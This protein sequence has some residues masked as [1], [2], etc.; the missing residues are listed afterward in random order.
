MVMWERVV[1]SPEGFRGPSPHH[2]MDPINALQAAIEGY[3]VTTMNEASKEGNIFD[4]TTGGADTIL[5]QHFEQMK[6]DAIVCNIG[7]FDVEIEVKW[8][9]ENAVETVNIKPQ[10]VCYWLKNGRRIIL[11]PKG[12][13]VNLGCTMGHPSFMMS[14]SFMNQLMTQIEL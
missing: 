4:T 13:L 7:H 2:Q 12:H 5:G 1:P 10:V 11:L 14:N 6:D 9:G 8:L 3:E